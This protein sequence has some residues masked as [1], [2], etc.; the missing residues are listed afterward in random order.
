MDYSQK[1][2]SNWDLLV[3]KRRFT[4]NKKKLLPATRLNDEKRR[5]PD[6]LQH[7]KLLTAVIG[8]AYAECRIKSDIR[9]NTQSKQ[10][11]N[12]VIASCLTIV[13]VERNNNCGNK[14]EGGYKDKYQ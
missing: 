12:Y 5:H 3:A 11:Y 8:G 10:K 14:Q 6:S 7:D 2:I 1:F 13:Y 4:G 9:K